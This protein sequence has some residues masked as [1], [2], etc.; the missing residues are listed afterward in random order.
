VYRWVD[1]EGVSHFSDKPNKHPS[2]EKI[3]IKTDAVRKSP[4]QHQRLRKQKHLLSVMDEERK[5]KQQKQ[6]EEKKKKDAKA[7][8]CKSA[9]KTLD[10]YLTTGRIFDIDKSGNK[11]YLSDQERDNEIQRARDIVKYWCK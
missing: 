10:N 2:E 7:H 5:I 6:V 4:V 11:V 1:E 3:E 8:N 9:R